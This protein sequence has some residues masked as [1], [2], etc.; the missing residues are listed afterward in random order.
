MKRI[1]ALDDSLSP[2]RDYLVDKG[3]Q[4]VD[5]HDSN[6]DNVSAVIVNS[7]DDNFMGIQDTMTK[8]PVIEAT[9]LTPEQIVSELE[10][11]ITNRS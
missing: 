11:R 9:G 7:I 4:V 6:F 10:N 8:A 1:I 3:Y 2:I 5:I